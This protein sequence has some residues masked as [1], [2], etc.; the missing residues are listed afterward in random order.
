MPNGVLV[1]LRWCMLPPGLKS[2]INTHRTF[3][4]PYPH[5]PESPDAAATPHTPCPRRSLALCEKALLLACAR[6]LTSGD[7]RAAALQPRLPRGRHLGQAARCGGLLDQAAQLLVHVGLVA[8]RVVLAHDELRRELAHPRGGDR[9]R[10][11]PQ[12]EVAERV[13][14]RRRP[15]GSGWLR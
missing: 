11:S 9:A 2:T 14:G 8:L 10:R 12:R 1:E 3:T 15:P 13:G 7:D 6:A 4:L 5:I